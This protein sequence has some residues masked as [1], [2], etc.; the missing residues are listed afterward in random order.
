MNAFGFIALIV[1]WLFADVYLIVKIKKIKNSDRNTGRKIAL[2][3][4]NI[5]LAAIVVFIAL[6]V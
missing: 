6:S 5:I 4:L 3:G 2:I 1:A